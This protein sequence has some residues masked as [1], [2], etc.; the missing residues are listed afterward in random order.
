MRRLLTPL[1]LAA[2]ALMALPVS[3]QRPPNLEPIPEPPLGPVPVNP[4][5]SS[6]EP[7]VTIRQQGEDT[8]EEFRLNGQ[9]Y[10][11]RV[12]PKNGPPFYL[13]APPGGGAI[14]RGV[15][16]GPEVRPTMWNVFSW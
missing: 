2:A 16:T 10:M 1:L 3:A 5:D 14:S 12:V 7:Q 6:L 8:V 15:D 11:I 13:Q 9:V 4:N